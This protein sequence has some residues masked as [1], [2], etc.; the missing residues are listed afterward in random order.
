MI[1]QGLLED[2]LTEKLTLDKRH[3]KLQ[4]MAGDLEDQL[5][6][7]G[8]QIEEAGRLIEDEKGQKLVFRAEAIQKSSMD[9]EES[10]IELRKGFVQL[11]KEAGRLKKVARELRQQNER[12]GMEV[13]R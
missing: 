3:A 1:E 2:L 13:G 11:R 10:L 9:L 12:A 7:L 5:K 4:R 8:K 6:K